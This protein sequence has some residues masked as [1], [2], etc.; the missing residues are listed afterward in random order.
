M[1]Q[2]GRL[3][4]LKEMCLEAGFKSAIR[5]LLTKGERE[6]SPD[7]WTRNRERATANGGLVE[8]RYS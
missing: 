5:R 6:V 8:S 4:A 7:R 1:E 3:L 2:E